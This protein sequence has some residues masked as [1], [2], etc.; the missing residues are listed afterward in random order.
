M[1][2][3]LDTNVLVSAFTTR[4]L[5]FDTLQAVVAEHELVLGETVMAELRRVL[6]QK[7]GM[8]EEIVH[9]TEAFLRREAAVT[10]EVA[11]LPLQPSDPDDVPVVGEAM[12]IEA[13]V[14]VT[15]DRALLEIGDEA[16]LPVLSPR[17]FWDWLRSEE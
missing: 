6:P 11:S 12:A 8:P 16:P 17:A 4:G 10:S 7:M 14:F 13:H 5:C 1:R 3:F 15:G 2:V 9:E